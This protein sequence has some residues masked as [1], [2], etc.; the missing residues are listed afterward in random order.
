MYSSFTIASLLVALIFLTTASFTQLGIAIV[1]YPILA[2]CAYQIF[3]RND[4]HYIGSKPKV[5]QKPQTTTETVK[6]PNNT[7]RISDIDKQVFLKLL[8]GTGLFLFISAFLSKKT[9]SLFSGGTSPVLEEVSLKDPTGNLIAPAQKQI[10][11]GY[12]ISEI[13]DN[14]TAA[15]YGFINKKGAWYITRV[16]TNTGSVRYF[17]GESN[18]SGNWNNREKLKYDY[19]NNAFKHSL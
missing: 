13:D 3:L 6:T 19:L 10:T 7:V 17:S 4:R 8:G 5:V 2:F 15:F 12:L 1:L 14:I 16:D 9:T 11:D 18:F